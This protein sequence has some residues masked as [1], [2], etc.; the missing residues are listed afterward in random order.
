MS[1]D[2]GRAVKAGLV[3]GL[4]FLILEM[5]L[6]GTVGG[7]SPW[8]PPRMIGAMV[9]GEGV[10]PP[11]ATFDLTVVLVAMAVHF[12]LSIILA[13]IFGLLIGGRAFETPVLLLLGGVFGLVVYFVNFYGMTAVWPWFEMARNWI[14]IFAHIVYGVVLAWVF[15]GTRRTGDVID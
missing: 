7:G 11:P 10:L 3:A 2:F 12:I 9:L 4:V 1:V 13:V 14:S 5:V 6:V 15:A 8:G